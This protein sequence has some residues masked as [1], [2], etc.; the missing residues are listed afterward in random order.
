MKKKYKDILRL[1]QC[2]YYRGIEEMF[3]Q[4]LAENEAVRLFFINENQAFT[5][6]RNIVVDPAMDQLFADTEALINTEKFMGLPPVFS[7]DPWNALCMITRAQNIHECLHILYTDFPC[8]A[9]IDERCN[10]KA[11]LKTMT[12]IS[13][14]IEDAYIEAA[15]CSVFDNLELYLKFGRISRIFASSPSAGTVTRKLAKESR[16][17]KKALIPL[18]LYLDYM[19]GFLLYPMFKLKAPPE[20]IA[21]YVDQTKQ[22]FLDGS[23]ASSPAERYK[24]CGR[25][26]DLILPLIPEDETLIATAN[27]DKYLGG[28]KTHS[29][30]AVTIGK[31]ANK[32]KTQKVTVR[33][34]TDLNGNPRDS[35]DY[36][37]QIL[38]L[39]SEFAKH[40]QA[41]LRIIGYGGNKSVF[42]GQDFDCAVLH[43]NIKINE[44]KPKINLN[45]K[46]AYQNIYN[47]YRVNIN[48]YNSRFGQL[49]EGRAP[50]K[51]DRLLFG[52]GISSKFL[53]DPKKRYWYRNIEGAG[54]PDLA[55]LLLID[56]S[57]S[58]WGVR[59]QSA[60]I[61]AV[62]LHEVLQKQGIC[63]A[64][65]EH[66]GCFEKPEIDINVLVDF[67]AREE[68]KYNLM[69]VD[70]Y[71]DNRD[72]LA[73]FW[74]ERYINQHVSSENK[75][76]IVL[77]DGVPA[78][79]A[80]GYYPPVSTKD[81]AN[82]VRKIT[83]RG[84]D[85][86]AIALDD[87][88]SFACYDML[89]EIYPNIIS[90]NDLKRLTGQLL[91][92]ISK[93]LR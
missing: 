81:T 79:E 61:S 53:G 14:I 52:A 42:F 45:L 2:E 77:S 69:Q 84:T 85:I 3:A 50:R 15:G 30:D 23:A 35:K 36:R 55:V 24:Y 27:L 7:S 31:L 93:R 9:V 41:A 64:I 46:K 11:K 86:I 54:V 39:L 19:A 65:V 72:G 5:D 48:S 73:L 47:R 58:M 90:C 17:Q 91:A 29:P 6:G 87:A 13:N 28:L 82:A 56:G 4:T 33:L 89:K 10:T 8:A 67:N 70:A 26:F 49:L 20:D 25:I 1:F 59:R 34:F 43:K 21:W 78:H 71:G 37:E 80:D 60:M 57:G 92:V 38:T 22:L 83:R 63:H 12:L 18:V 68:E 88:G 40:K 76:I 62:I 74:A 16:K 66:R 44:S 75:L 51:E 32:G